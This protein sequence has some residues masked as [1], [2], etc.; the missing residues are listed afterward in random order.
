[1]KSH[2]QEEIQQQKLKNMMRTLFPKKKNHF[3]GSKT[4]LFK[5]SQICEEQ[6]SK[7]TIIVLPRKKLQKWFST[8]VAVF[9]PFLCRYQDKMREI[10]SLFTIFTLRKYILKINYPHHCGSSTKFNIISKKKI[11]PK[12]KIYLKF[13][14]YAIKYIF[15]SIFNYIHYLKNLLACHLY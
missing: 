15:K 4:L 14:T 12:F 7:D 6:Y 9:L 5:F 2:H 3:S 13:L 1:M 8:L 10:F 11:S